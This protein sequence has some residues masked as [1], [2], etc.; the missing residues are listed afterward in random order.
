MAEITKPIGVKKISKFK[1]IKIKKTRP[2]TQEM[3]V[4]DSEHVNEMR[5]LLA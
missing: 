4:Y 2:L 5:L 1:S 3:R